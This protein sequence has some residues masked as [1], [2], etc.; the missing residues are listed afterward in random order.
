MRTKIP[1][2]PEKIS[3][4]KEIIAMTPKERKEYL[5]E[6]IF[7]EKFF[8]RNFVMKNASIPVRSETGI[9][10]VKIFKFKTPRIF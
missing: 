3:V 7:L 6:L 5:N 9:M 8:A 2:T 1:K 4:T 10:S